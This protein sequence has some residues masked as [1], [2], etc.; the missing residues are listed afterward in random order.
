MICCDSQSACPFK[1][2]FIDGNSVD[3]CHMQICLSKPGSTTVVVP[4]IPF[5]GVPPHHVRVPIHQY[6]SAVLHA[7]P[8]DQKCSLI[9]S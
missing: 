6:S 5:F 2:W 7:L 8:F 4:I 1:G 3:T 9:T